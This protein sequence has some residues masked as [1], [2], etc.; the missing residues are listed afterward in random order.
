MVEQQL[1]LLANTD[2]TALLVLDSCRWDVFHDVS[3]AGRCVESPAGDTVSWIKRVGPILNERGVR[4][5]SAN[6]QA[7]RCVRKSCPAVE[8]RRAWTRLWARITSK[9]IPSV[10]PFA[11]NGWVVAELIACKK[12]I[13]VHYIQPHFPAIGNPPLSISQWTGGWNEFGRACHRLDNPYTA[14]EGGKTTVEQI[15]R[16]YRANVELVWDAARAL[17]VNL[18]RFRKDRVV[19]TSDHAELLGE[20]AS[21][22]TGLPRFGHKD[23]WEVPVLRQVPWVEFTDEKEERLDA[24]KALGYAS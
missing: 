17:V 13:V 1:D 10:H 9:R 3:D 12:P 16:A 19:L 7:G 4:Y 6:P 18:R 2:W 22:G 20:P 8:V 15:Q 11:L 24:L 14:I 5:F 23:K 21:D